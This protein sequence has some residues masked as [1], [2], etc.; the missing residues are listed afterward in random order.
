MRFRCL[1]FVADSLEGLNL[2]R[3]PSITPYCTEHNIVPEE[4][5]REMRE[6]VHRET[7]LT[8]SAGIAP[9]KVRTPQSLCIPTQI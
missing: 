6:V 3:A 8:V 4:C 1:V 5:V 2:V 7:D 9:N